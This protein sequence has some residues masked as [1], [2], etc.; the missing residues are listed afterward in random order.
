MLK[1]YAYKNC[2]T[3]RKAVKWLK[4]NDIAFE[5]IAIREQPPTVAELKRVLKTRAGELRT[6]FNTSGGDYKADAWKDK[7]PVISEADALKALTAN[8]N[9]VKRPL[10][11]DDS[12][13]VAINGFKED[14]WQATLLS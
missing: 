10:L 1:L 13:V 14:E 3:C 5:E 12:G 11:V 2:D 6:L 7:L 4:A 8:G 9:L